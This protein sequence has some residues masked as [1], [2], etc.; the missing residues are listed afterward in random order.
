MSAAAGCPDIRD[1]ARAVLDFVEATQAVEDHWKRNYS[2]VGYSN[3]RVR[4]VRRRRK[5][6]VKLLSVARAA[7]DILR[8]LAPDEK[9]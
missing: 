3:G 2:N 8:S 7:E 6:T 4:L 9:E 1:V 5:A